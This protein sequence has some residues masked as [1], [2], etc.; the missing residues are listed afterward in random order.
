MSL[1]NLNANKIPRI[2]KEKLLNKKISRLFNFFEREF[3]I[4]NKFI[5][6]VSLFQI[7]VPSVIHQWQQ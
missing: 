7:F 6:A 5:V 4:R 2:L 3:N 1:K